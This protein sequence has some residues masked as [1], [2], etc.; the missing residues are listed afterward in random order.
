VKRKFAQKQYVQ[1]CFTHLF[2]LQF[3][4]VMFLQN[5]IGKKA[6]HDRKMLVK[7]IALFTSFG[8][9]LMLEVE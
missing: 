9:G 2:F 4:F 7:S 6:A 5:N 1:K 8:S 3:G